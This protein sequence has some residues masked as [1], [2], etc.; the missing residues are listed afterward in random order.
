[1]N[2]IGTYQ[3]AHK[4]YAGAPLEIKKL[5]FF[6]KKIEESLQTNVHLFSISERSVMDGSLLLVK[7]VFIHLLARI[8]QVFVTAIAGLL[9]IGMGIATALSAPFGK[10][11]E[12]FIEGGAM[13]LVGLYLLTVGVAVDGGLAVTSPLEG[14]YEATRVFFSGASVTENGNEFDEL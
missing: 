2:E 1:M 7:S 4:W 13:V 10:G 6:P 8:A 9:I 3:I 5:S 14:I 11:L 12:Q